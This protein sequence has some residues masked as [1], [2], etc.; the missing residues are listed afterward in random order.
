ML[1]VCVLTNYFDQVTMERDTFPAIGEHRRG[2]N[3]QGLCAGC[4]ARDVY[5]FSPGAP[6]LYFGCG[7]AACD[8]V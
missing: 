5:T 2:S 7:A 6:G 8:C 4:V 1:A 3:C